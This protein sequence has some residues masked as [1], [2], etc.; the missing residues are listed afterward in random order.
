MIHS[1]MPAT[2]HEVVVGQVELALAGAAFDFVTPNVIQPVLLPF[3]P[4]PEL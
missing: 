4:P 1:G 2:I 3:T